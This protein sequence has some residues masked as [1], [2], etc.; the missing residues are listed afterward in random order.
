MVHM[1]SEI[2]A[3]SSKGSAIAPPP[4]IVRP[5]R[6]RGIFAAPVSFDLLFFL[7]FGA[8][9]VVLMLVGLRRM[10]WL[11]GR[12]DRKATSGAVNW[13]VDLNEMLQPQLP[14]A[15]QIQRMQEEGEE[16][17]DDGDPP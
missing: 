1:S 4:G 2:S 16:D 15:E 8:S 12:G 9:I 5:T 10:G 14:R 11:G 7:A 17:E 3:L 13:M 6:A